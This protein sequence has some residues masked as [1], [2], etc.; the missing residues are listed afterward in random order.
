MKTANS[1]PS[2]IAR[3]SPRAEQQ[4]GCASRASL[5]SP[6]TP[7]APKYPQ[8]L[9]PPL[10]S[11]STFFRTHMRWIKH[12]PI[13]EEECCCCWEKWS[14]WR[15][16]TLCMGRRSMENNIHKT[17]GLQTHIGLESLKTCGGGGVT[18]L[19]LVDAER[20]SPACRQSLG[21]WLIKA[22]QA[23]IGASR[24]R[25]CL[26]GSRMQWPGCAGLCFAGGGGERGEKTKE[27]NRNPFIRFRRSAMTAARPCPLHQPIA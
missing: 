12:N 15:A 5:A 24:T 2:S 4:G 20:G 1:S 27:M 11:K 23:R 6:T 14:S 10:L 17:W 9:L 3:C 26:S 22:T 19:T 7:S 21:P 13:V 18:L 16:Q 25:S 8:M